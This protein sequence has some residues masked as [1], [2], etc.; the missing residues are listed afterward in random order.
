MQTVY[1]RVGGGCGSQQ[2]EVAN[3]ADV[4]F[5]DTVLMSITTPHRTHRTTSRRVIG[6]CGIAESGMRKVKI[7]NPKM[8]KGLRNGG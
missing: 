1:A 4:V 6:K 8:W 3:G 7:R 2:R 5:T